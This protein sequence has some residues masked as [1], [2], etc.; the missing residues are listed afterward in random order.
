[1]KAAELVALASAH[2]IDLA[3]VAGNASELH[4]AAA[5]RRPN[6]DERRGRI[7]VLQTARGPESRS[8]RRP[9]WS[10][11]EIGQAAQGVPR[12]PWLAACHS[13]AGDSSGYVELHRGLMLQGLNVATDENWPMAVRKRDGSR[14]YYH[15]ELAALVLDVEMHGRLFLE[16]PALHAI[17]IGVTDDLW[18]HVVIHWYASLKGEYERWLGTAR[19]M[20][21]K[22]IMDD[23]DRA[24]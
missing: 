5:Q 19:G 1:M 2:G 14:G 21:Q 24:A 23:G 6:K 20:I 15:A 4:K 3:H 10:V 9:A 17:C 11:A 12:M 13:F 16:A 8:Y 22:W 18:E 7:P